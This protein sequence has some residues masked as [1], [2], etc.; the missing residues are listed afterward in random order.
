MATL[1]F[2]A[3]GSAVGASLLPGSILGISGATI[4]SQLGQL[5]GAYVDQALFGAAGQG[6]SFEGPRLDELRVTASSEGAPIPR[7]YGAA[8]VSGQVIWA[9]E[10]EEVRSTSSAGGQSKGGALGGG[11]ATSVSYAY[12]ANFAVSL[13]EG[14]ITGLG[15]VWADGKEW[16]FSDV[17]YR[18]YYGSEDQAPDA[19]IAAKQGATGAPA[20]RGTAYIVF[21]RLPLADFGNRLPQLSFEIF[22]AVDD[23][24]KQIKGTVIIPGSGE[25]VYATE[26]VQRREIFGDMVAENVHT[27]EAPTNWSASMDQMHRSL[28]NVGSVSLVTCWFGDDLRAGQCR[29]R[30]GV[31]RANK[32]TRPLSWR[33]AGMERSAA[34]VVSKSD[35]RP[36]YG[37][38][39]TDASIVQA[40]Q[41][42]AARDIKAVLT[43]FIL[44]DVP[45]S[46]ALVDP[47]TAAV[48]Q[49][50]Y[51]WRG[52]I[53]VDPAPGVAGT[54]D[55]TAL[56]ANQIAAF[57]G[58]AAVSDY[59]VSDEEVIY[60]GPDE[61]SYRRFILHYA[62][63]AIAAGGADAFVIGT[64]LRGLTWARDGDG[65]Y[66]FVSA[67]VQLAA[68]VK[69]L[70]GP[71]TK[72]TY[73]ADWSEYF[74][75]QPADGSGDVYFHL[76]PLWA[77]L[78]IDA[79]GIDLYWP[80]SDWRD[81]SGHL[82]AAGARSIYDLDYLKGN[83]NGGEGYD[84]YYASENDRA[85]Q[86]RTPITDGQGKPWVFRYKDLANW[87]QRD[88]YNRPGGT[89]TG[90]P[91]AW[92]PQ[93]KPVWLMEIGCAAIDKGAN[94]PNVFYDPKST[95]S[96]LPH[97]AKR[98]RD[99][100]M[101]R[102]YLQALIEGL[103]PA[104]AGYVDGSNP[105]STVYTGPMI[106]TSR[107]H[108]YAWDARAYPAFPN[109]VETWSDS[110]NWPYGHWING[111]IA[112]MPLADAI[113]AMFADYGFNAVD[114]SELEGVLPGY[115]IDRAMSLREALQNVETAFFVDTIESGRRIVM[116]H[117]GSG[118]PV[119]V[120]SPADLV[121]LKPQADLLTITRGQE[122]EL[123][124]EVKI[125]H[126]TAGG[127][128]RRA[129]S[130]ARRLT[131]FSER[132]ATASLA[133][134]LEPD[135]AQSI[136]ETW[137]QEAWAARRRA[138]FTL[139]P[140]MLAVEP[141]DMIETEAAGHRLLHRITGISDHGARTIEALSVEPP[142]YEPHETPQ[143]VQDIPGQPVTGRA[144][145]L[146]L[147]LPLVR[148]GGSET[149]GYVALHQ[150]PWPGRMAVYQSPGDDEFTLAATVDAAA[151]I[152]TL[153][154]PFPGGPPGRIDYA[155][156]GRVILA[157][158]ELRSV[159][160]LALFDGANALA[161]KRD[162]DSWEVC[163]FEMAELVGEL[164]YELT[165]WL[166]GQL[167]TESEDPIGVVTASA[168]QPVVL[169]DDSVVR[170]PVGEGGIA[171]PLNWQY[172]PANRVIGHATY[173]QQSHAFP[174]LARR[175]YAP[176][177]VR[178][179]R[180]PAGDLD[181]SWIRRTRTGGD[182]WEAAEV[183]LGEEAEAYD[184]DILDG[185]NVVRTLTTHTPA[186][187]Y[188]QAQQIEDFGA[189]QSLVRCRVHQMSA[190]WGR[191]RAHTIAV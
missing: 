167:G 129:V 183:A 191:G 3:I 181:L 154:T 165:G 108:V 133:M 38:T 71:Q 104:N 25:F 11:S 184:I 148:D 143:R 13:A 12:F 21:E 2:Q 185:T 180:T 170:F 113:R 4:G 140:S 163:Q 59:T 101:Q 99:D 14:E 42:L 47:Y 69:A 132:V 95:E 43:P 1:A 37:G 5:A 126:A 136:A 174:G 66:P 50:A 39:P 121:A 84:W 6:R 115:L 178:G 44:M 145:A 23:L 150:A 186:A 16:D 34:Y 78:D 19:L 142:I 32:I 70:L 63:L 74:G 169:L 53:T 18:V 93:S 52:R 35:D 81:G 33:V 105:S 58:T 159:N 118:E 22:R 102:V 27:R 17:A 179:R 55:K 160:R 83:I 176:V 141:G 125:S 91:T 29:V 85:A 171:R 152:G 107:M 62:H 175:P 64:E 177:H 31:E 189:L 103:D 86:M 61:W 20:Y 7:V 15:R 90:T 190:T 88:H 96:Q 100:F 97:F 98:R 156:R 119:G 117:R 76:D 72:V 173:D 188:S 110:L 82:D 45:E 79:I 127:D 46:N 80:L 135:Q 41:D 94:Q 161:V 77:S 60:T 8:R 166:R 67:L 48:G 162:D 89:E 168:G 87:W 128:Y 28:P 153:M 131:G 112:S 51:P 144:D 114:A 57:V 10:F 146:F 123:P 9:T 92:Q 124:A 30:P 151:T 157:S 24:H 106:D 149:D 134:M 164:T 26:P 155:T 138:K 75:H 111:R 172:G 130:E 54:A 120:L 56:A 116:R 139:P 187:S 147:D 158:G 109:D 40:I 137:L 36:A 122:T 182:N 73:A 65:S 68:D 49:P